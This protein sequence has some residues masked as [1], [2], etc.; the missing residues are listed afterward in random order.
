MM[1]SLQIMADMFDL[2]CGDYCLYGYITVVR[3]GSCILYF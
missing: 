1:T 3:V 2:F